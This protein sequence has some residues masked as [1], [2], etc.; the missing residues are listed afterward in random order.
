MT[1]HDFGPFLGIIGIGLVAGS[2]L[3][4]GVG[5]AGDLAL[6]FLCGAVL[7]VSTPGAPSVFTLGGLYVLGCVFSSR[8]GVGSLYLLFLSPFGFTRGGG[9]WGRWCAYDW[10]EPR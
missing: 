1:I 6:R 2:T 8:L 10:V 7:S 5:F 9:C 4:A 3:G